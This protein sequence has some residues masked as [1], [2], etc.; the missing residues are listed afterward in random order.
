MGA[1]HKYDLTSDVTHLIVG[2]IDTLKYKYV[3]KERPD[4]KVVI[5]TWIHAIRDLWMEGEDTDVAALEDEYRAPIFL[6]LKLCLTG[7][8]DGG[9]LHGSAMPK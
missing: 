7:F 2:S 9:S 1:V 4:V 5:P 8:D 3:A 6:G